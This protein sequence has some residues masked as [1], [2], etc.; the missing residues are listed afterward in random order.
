MSTDINKIMALPTEKDESPQTEETKTVRAVKGDLMMERDLIKHMKMVRA[1]IV[2]GENM[3]MFAIG[4]ENY[5]NILMDSNV[6]RRADGNQGC[7]I[8]DK[9]SKGGS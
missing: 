5:S 4:T 9:I 2:N 6:N 7:R 1:Q 3:I 8:T